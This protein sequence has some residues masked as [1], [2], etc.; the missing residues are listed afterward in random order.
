[1]LFKSDWKGLQ[2]KKK[3][4]RKERVERREELKR[5]REREREK[6]K[7]RMTSQGFNKK[8]HENCK[9]TKLRVT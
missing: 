2:V 3:K 6:G 7:K 8:K 9:P 5:E 1:M 4:E